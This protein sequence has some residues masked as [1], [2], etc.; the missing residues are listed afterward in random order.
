[1]IGALLAA[2]LSTGAADETVLPCRQPQLSRTPDA[3]YVACGTPTAILVARSVDGGRRF[4]EPARIGITGHLSLGNHRGPRIAASGNEVAVTAIVGALGSGKDGDLLAWSSEDGGRRWSAPVVVNDVPASAREGLHAMTRNHSTVTAA[5]L[6]LRNKGT[7][8]AVGTSTDGGRTWGQDVI[9]YRAPSG[10]ICECCH[11]SLATD[12]SQRVVTMFRNSVG[13]NRD[14]YVIGSGDGRTWTPARKLG[15]ESWTLAACPMDGGDIRYD[16]RGNAVAVWRRG[17]TIFLTSLDDDAALSVERRIGDGVNA[18]LAVTAAGPAVAWNGSDGLQL[19]RGNGLPVLVDSRGR[20]AS[21]VAHG[22]T[23]VV[24]F[25]R[26][27][28]SVVRVY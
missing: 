26:G 3:V 9:A 18:A 27:E 25:E 17:Q 11:P 14:M 24:A 16:S 8:L 6:D 5:W 10:G 2:S 7:S 22:Q 23:V 12:G 4:D 13:G 21:L 19:V 20:F 28:E 1:V 15:R